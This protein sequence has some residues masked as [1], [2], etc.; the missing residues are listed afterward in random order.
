MRHDAG[1]FDDANR[2]QDTRTKL[3]E[4]VAKLQV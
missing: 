4:R 3:D 1:L 2:A